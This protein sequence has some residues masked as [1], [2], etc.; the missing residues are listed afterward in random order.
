[1][2]TEEQQAAAWGSLSRI[3]AQLRVAARNLDTLGPEVPRAVLE[4]VLVAVDGMLVGT[5]GLFSDVC[6]ELG[7]LLPRE[8]GGGP[9]TPCP[10]PAV[11]AE[12]LRAPGDRTAAP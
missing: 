8:S 9:L 2:V 12:A 4:T 10:E 5:G 1:M 11:S 6:W 7:V 3:A